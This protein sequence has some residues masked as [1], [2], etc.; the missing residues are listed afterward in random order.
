MAPIREFRHRWRGLSNFSPHSAILDGVEYP[1]VEHAYQAS[2]TLH[3][4]EREQIL[5]T[6]TPGQA[7]R[8]GRTVTLRTDWGDEF[9]VGV[10]CDLINNKWSRHEDFRELLASTGDRFIYEG[11]HWGDTFW[12]VSLP[13]LIGMNWLGRILMSTRAYRG[14]AYDEE[15]L[16]MLK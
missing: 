7:K 14:D 16:M 2:K 6:I 8:I 5:L 9:K 13:D 15:V 12:G 3:P 4:D 10:M 1:T 11:N